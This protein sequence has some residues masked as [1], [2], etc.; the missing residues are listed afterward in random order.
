M[1]FPLLYV[2]FEVDTVLLMYSRFDGHL[3]MVLWDK[4]WIS[5]DK[6]HKNQELD[7]KQVIN[8]IV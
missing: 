2:M 7:V 6:K 4:V 5:F 1:L 8:L 3:R